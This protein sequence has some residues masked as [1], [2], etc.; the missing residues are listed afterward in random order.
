[1]YGVDWA[2]TAAGDTAEQSCADGGGGTVV[3]TCD[4]T[5]TW[6]TD[7]TVTS[8]GR[9]FFSHGPQV[10][11]CIGFYAEENRCESSVCNVT[12]GAVDTVGH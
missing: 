5:G 10:E 11:D 12:A 9:P 8:C 6:D 4:G 1:M 7:L 3:R 2:L